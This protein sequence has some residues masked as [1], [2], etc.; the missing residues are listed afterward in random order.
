MT[1]WEFTRG[2]APLRPPILFDQQWR[3]V[4]F[5]HWPVEPATITHLFPPGCRPDV[6]E[7]R[8]YV[9]LVPFQLLDAGFSRLGRI[10]Y[11]G[12]FAETNIR[13]YSVDDAG[14]HGVVFC[15]LDTARLAI[16]PLARLLFGVP[17]TWSRMRVR[18]Q[19]GG[20]W[21]Y[22]ARRR[23]PQRGL[24]STVTIRVAGPVEPTPLEQWLTARWGL[25]A[26]IRGRTR[27]VPN[28]HDQ[29]P[30]H[31]AEVVGLRDDLL[32]ASGVM[33]AGDRL[34]ALWSPGVRAQFGRP[35]PLD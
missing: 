23:W 25:H 24:A 22:Q 31:R 35:V 1:E 28:A 4:A 12:S 16:V 11:F 17:Y 27:W 19:P 30:L 29:W 9:G 7:G 3:N 32:A 2:A 33:P 20:V 13:L 34:P 10:P 15:S 6:V 26:C 18:E 8:S 5:L 21:Q 14:R